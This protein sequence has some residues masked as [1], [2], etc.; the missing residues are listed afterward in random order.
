MKRLSV[1]LVFL[2]VGFVSSVGYAT[3]TK[4]YTAKGTVSEKI[5]GDTEVVVNVSDAYTPTGGDPTGWKGIVEFTA[6]NDFTGG[7]ICSNGV[8]EATASG[9]FG[10]GTIRLEGSDRIHVARLNVDKGVF[11]N[12]FVLKDATTDNS[13]PALDVLK[14]ATLNGKVSI[15][16]DY[17]VLT[18]GA[19][20]YFKLGASASDSGVTLTLND[21][22]NAGAARFKVMGW[23]KVL[24]KEKVT[25]ASV[26]FGHNSADTGMADFY[27]D[28]A[29]KGIRLGSFDIGCH[30]ANQ[31]KGASVQ[32]DWGDSWYANGH[33]R[34]ILNGFDQE[35]RYLH[36]AAEPLYLS[37]SEYACGIWTDDKKPC[38]VTINGRGA[39]NQSGT[40]YI[41]F[42]GP[43]SIVIEKVEPLDSGWS[44]YQ[45]F[46]KR[47]SSVTNITVKSGQF[48]FMT[49]ASFPQLLNID[50]LGGSVTY[51]SV[52]SCVPNVKR[53]SVA[54]GAAVTSDAKSVAPITV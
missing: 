26:F 12:D 53:I 28:N 5:T 43:I 45:G 4:T 39:L 6:E 34:I 47:E 9:A 50:V 35:F 15:D 21:E 18:T 25:A 7:I 17:A 32:F 24:F 3:E 10:T 30:L 27:A 11:P 54:S 46:K 8:V 29:I 19:Y 42:A 49:G 48:R 51:E 14:S 1:A 36:S 13:Y 16:S 31:F 40:A 41:R 33:C 23:G 20:F 37:G 2:L 52:S 44:L 22:A 38:T